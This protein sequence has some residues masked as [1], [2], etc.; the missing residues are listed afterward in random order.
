[1]FREESSLR[2]KKKGKDKV[3]PTKAKVPAQPPKEGPGSS[4]NTSFFF[5]QYVMSGRKKDTSGEEDPREALLRY[6]KKA[7]ADPVFVGKAYAHTQP[8]P[9]LES[10]TLEQEREE[11]EQ[12]RRRI[13]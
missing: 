10:R 8:E 12:Q 11:Q 2:R 9:Q 6:A 13:I 5:T 1:M 4:M 3:D 7:K